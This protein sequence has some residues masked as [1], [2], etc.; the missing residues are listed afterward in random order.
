[1]LPRAI[2]ELEQRIILTDLLLRQRPVPGTEAE[3][4]YHPDQDDPSIHIYTVVCPAQVKDTSQPGLMREQNVTICLRVT[5]SQILAYHDVRTLVDDIHLAICEKVRE[6]Q[7]CVLVYEDKSTD[8]SS[9]GDP[10]GGPA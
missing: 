1:M 8:G 2:R 7:S 4:E 3:I 10:T 9:D 5:A 6:A